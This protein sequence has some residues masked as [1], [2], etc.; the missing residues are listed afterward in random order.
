MS[1][2]FQDLE[3]QLDQKIRLIRRL[4][5]QIKSFEASLKGEGVEKGI[6]HNKKNLAVVSE[7]TKLPFCSSSQ[8][9]VDPH[10]PQGLPGHAGVQE[11]GRAQAHSE[12]HPG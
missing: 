8:A 2:F 7:K 10:H 5:N 3:E 11:G 1:L 6:K 12:H 4:Q 9:D